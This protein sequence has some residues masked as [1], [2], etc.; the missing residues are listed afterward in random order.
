[1]PLYIDD[2]GIRARFTNLNVVYALQAIKV[3][4][5]ITSVT[6]AVAVR[7]IRRYLRPLVSDELQIAFDKKQKASW[8]SIYFLYIE[9]GFNSKNNDDLWQVARAVHL[10]YTNTTQP[11]RN[12]K[13][14]PIEVNTFFQIC[15][16]LRIP[17][18]E[19]RYPTRNWDIDPLRF[20]SL[21]WRQPLPGRKLCGHHAPSG[22]N[23]FPDDA[24]NAAA[25]YKAGI[26]QKELF[27]KTVNH[28]L[29]QESIEFHQSSFKA[30]TLLPE[31]D[32]ASWLA[33][34]R[35]EVWRKL[36]DR[37]HELDDENAVQ[38]LLDTLHNSRSLSLKTKT[39]YKIVNE[40]IKAYPALIWPMWLRAERWYQSRHILEKNRGGKRPGAGNHSKP[41]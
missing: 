23:R 28:I 36:G 17:M 26:R 38:I 32:I 22:P 41:K 18:E 34:R 39:L 20:C 10:I 27:D 29:T 9:L 7:L 8:S 30:P 2:E 1:M 11:P 6:P 4:A 12:L 3:T 15:G 25:R 21:C 19:L 14:A 37:Q 16:Y 31:R 35:P 5:S 24:R 40:H 13:F 33:E